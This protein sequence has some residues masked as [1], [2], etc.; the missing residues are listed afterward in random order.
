M[1]MNKLVKYSMAALLAIGLFSLNN[2]TVNAAT[3]YRRLT[4]NAYAYNIKGQRANK[5]LYRKGSKVRVIGSIELNGKKYNIISGN[6]YIKASNF[7]RRN[8]SALSNGYETSLLRNSYVYNTQGQRIRTKLHKGHSVTYYGRPVRINGKKYVQIGKEQ[9]V[10]ASN[11][12]L[13]YNGPTD[14]DSLNHTHHNTANN[15]PSRNTTTNTQQNTANSSLSNTTSNT[16]NSSTSTANGSTNNSSSNTS[17]SNQ[18][19]NTNQSGNNTD[20]SG[21]TDNGPLAT[22]DDYEQLSR[23]LQKLEFINTDDAT[24][25]KRKP[26]EAATSKAEDYLANRQTEPATVADIK[27]V[28]SDIN[29]AADNLDGDAENKKKPTLTVELSTRDNTRKTDW[30]PEAEKQ[31]LTIANELYGTDD[32][33]F[34]EGTDN[35][36]IGLTDGD[37][38]VFVLDSN[39]FYNSNYKYIN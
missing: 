35:K 20:S 34:I 25:V 3:G 14:S 1:K 18:S 22:K 4:H 37:G 16:A 24:W 11:V 36:S 2:Q 39:E 19:S 26:L 8:S 12:L 7:K 29:T 33:R 21:N 13:S 38:V 31:V 28:I 27:K 23:I 6:V 30:T 9:Y 10:R 17:S 15:T 5:K 32:A